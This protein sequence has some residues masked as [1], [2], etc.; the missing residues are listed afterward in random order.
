MAGYLDIRVNLIKGGVAKYGV[1]NPIFE[2]S[3]IQPDYKRHLIFEGISGDEDGKQYYLTEFRRRGKMAM[4]GR[5]TSPD[6][7]G[8]GNRR[9]K[10]FCSDPF[11]DS[12]LA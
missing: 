1:T 8:L 4:D 10:P 12:L 2:P 6:R 9:R 11:G 5:K 7:A 3:P